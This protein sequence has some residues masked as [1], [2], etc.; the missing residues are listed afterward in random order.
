MGK[1]EIPLTNESLLRYR[2]GE[3]HMMMIDPQK[4]TP[5]CTFECCHGGHGRHVAPPRDVWSGNP[6]TDK[7][8]A[9]ER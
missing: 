5:K 4:S 7:F 6:D 2:V 1:H 9:K 3:T 8:W